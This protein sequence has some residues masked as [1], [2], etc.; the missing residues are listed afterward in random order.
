MIA[1]VSGATPSLKTRLG[2]S[3][4]EVSERFVRIG[5]FHGRGSHI[6]AVGSIKTFGQESVQETGPGTHRL[7]ID[8]RLHHAVPADPRAKLPPATSLGVA[9]RNIVEA[10]APLYALGEWAKARDPRSLGLPGD[11]G[12]A[13]N[14]DRVGRALDRLFDANRAALASAIAVAAIRRFSIATDELHNDSTSITLSG[15]YSGADVLP[16]SGQ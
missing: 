4:R 9:V 3:E 8:D 10:R 6:G 5:A 11:A 2:G 14:D 7:G 13:L 15:R 16:I 12:G 1:P